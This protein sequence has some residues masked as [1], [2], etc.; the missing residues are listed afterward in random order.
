M[1][2]DMRP[3]RQKRPNRRMLWRVAYS[4]AGHVGG[5]RSADVAQISGWL[6]Y[7][8][9]IRRWHV[10]SGALRYYLIPV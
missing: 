10:E 7:Y 8:R 6:P 1:I 5:C 3:S 4:V 2:R 9:T